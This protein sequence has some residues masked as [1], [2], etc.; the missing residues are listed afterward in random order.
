MRVSKTGLGVDLLV[1]TTSISATSGSGVL[2]GL[3]RPETA[4]GFSSGWEA[5]R[6]GSVLGVFNAVAGCV[7]GA[8]GTLFSGSLV[9][10]TGAG[11]LGV[12]AMECFFAGRLLLVDDGTRRGV[13]LR[14]GP[15]VSGQIRQRFTYTAQ[16]AIST[17]AINKLAISDLDN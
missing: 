11:K 17:I 6:T 14:T 13:L 12:T 4:A 10:V 15:Q 5:T 3:G 1:V 9:V 2:T 16:E 8:A 7:A